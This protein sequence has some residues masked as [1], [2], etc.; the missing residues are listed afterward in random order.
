MDVYYNTNS[1]KYY[2]VGVK[3]SDLRFQGG[4]YLV[5]K[6]MYSQALI[7]EKM[8]QPGEDISMLQSKGYEFRLTFYKNEIIKY[9][10]KEKCSLKGFFRGLRKIVMV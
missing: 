10:K 2:F 4:T 5:D 3:F 9:E 8:L 7:N 6:D 1:N